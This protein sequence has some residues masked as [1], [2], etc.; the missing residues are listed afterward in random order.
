MLEKLSRYLLGYMTV[1]IRGGDKARFIN[2]AVRSKVNFWD[3]K[4]RP[5]K[6]E[7]SVKTNIFRR[8]R[9]ES[10]A[11]KTGVSLQFRD[12]R[13]LPPKLV[14]I[15]RRP[16]F[17]LGVV[18]SVLTIS[19]LSDRIW[20]LTTSGSK[21]YS[22]QEIFAAAEKLGV[23]LGADYDDF[24]PISVGRLM[25][26]ELPEIAWISINNDG[27]VTDISIKDR[28]MPPV[29]EEKHE[30]I[31]N[32]VAGKTGVVRSIEAYE[33][34][35]VAKIDH[36]VKEG[37]L[38]ITGIW[39]NKYGYTFK[40]SAY[41]KVMAEVQQDF[42]VRVPRKQI[43]YTVVSTA[44]KREVSIFSLRVPLSL[45]SAGFELY[46]CTQREVK[47][48]LLGMEL[49]ITYRETVYR[50]LSENI[51]IMTEAEWRGAAL[52]K[53]REYQEHYMEKGASLVSEKQ[54]ISIDESYCSIK[55]EC[56]FLEDIAI[57][58][59]VLTHESVLED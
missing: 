14:Y 41:G 1:E 56:V 49:P 15:K 11:R 13:G 44:V 35:P 53:L 20:V 31:F 46:D 17:L 12:I 9:L 6:E 39:Q 40:N 28:E 26:L 2:L 30:G 54:E 42:C 7:Y 8:G 43:T 34:L 18:L 5:D 23:A 55:S 58:Q 33:G 19:L 48:R 51:R 32:V 24:D 4:G 27:V 36:V 50:E 29:M 47:L 37:E 38:C 59:E 10:I 52:E 57:R 21:V 45:S 3:Y 22:N 25:M 16:G